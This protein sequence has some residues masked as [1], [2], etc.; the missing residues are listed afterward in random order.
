VDL[1]DALP[2]VVVDG[3]LTGVGLME[4]DRASIKLEWIQRVIDDP[5]REGVQADGRIRRW[6]NFCECSCCRTEKPCTTHFSIGGLCHE[7]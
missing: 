3:L 4:A 7:D 2:D 6:V 5:E 1:A